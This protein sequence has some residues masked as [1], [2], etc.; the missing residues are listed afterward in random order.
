MYYFTNKILSQNKVVVTMSGDM[1]DELYGGYQIILELKILSINQNMGW[2]YK[3]LDEKFAAPI[4]LNIKFDEN[5]FELL[6]VPLSRNFKSWWY[7]KFCDGTWLYNFVAE[8]FFT[9][10]DKF[11]N[12]FFNGGSLPYLQKYM[13]YCLAINSDHKFGKS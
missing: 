13:E 10:N 12:G 2:I 11:E 5:D 4:K 8:D 1:G 6:K 3:N 9:R 7:S